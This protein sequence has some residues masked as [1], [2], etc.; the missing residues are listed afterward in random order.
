[1]KLKA[2]AKINLFLNVVGKREDYHLLDM[3]NSSISLFD[4]VE[5]NIADKITSFSDAPYYAVA[6]KAAEKFCEIY[7]VS[8]VDIK[9]KKNIPFCGG[10]GG[11]S[12]DA[13]AVIYGMSKLFKK[14]LLPRDISRF[15]AVGADVPFMINGGLSK[16]VGIGE[17]VKPFGFDVKLFGVVVKGEGGNDT[18]KVFERFD[19]IG[20]LTE[21]TSETLSK[22]IENLG[23]YK[24]AKETGLLT[25]ADKNAF[26]SLKEKLFEYDLL[27]HTFNALTPA[28]KTLAPAIE[29][30]ECRLEELGA[31]K[32]LLT[33]SGSSVVGFFGKEKSKEIATVLEKEYPFVFPFE[34]VGKGVETVEE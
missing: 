31:K 8:G 22:A 12:A 7:G 25:D 13:A 9:I 2:H 27:E 23:A 1:M 34:T 15:A 11:S 14:T 4:E 6:T 19:E 30:I 5:L 32:V 3:I 18:K 29:K 33:G 16:V 10:L 28:A 17:V 20:E 21:K 26:S 24:K